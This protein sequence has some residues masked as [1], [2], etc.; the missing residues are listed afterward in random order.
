MKTE[1]HMWL[2]R[3]HMLF[4]INQRELQSEIATPFKT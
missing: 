1:E 2:K 4:D 3:T